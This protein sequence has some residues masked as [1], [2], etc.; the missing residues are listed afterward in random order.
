MPSAGRTVAA[1]VFYTINIAVEADYVAACSALEAA[2]PS[3]GLLPVAGAW[4]EAWVTYSA[5]AMVGDMANECWI[6]VTSSSAAA[7]T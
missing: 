1:Y 2:L 5:M 4:R 6:E 3:M 7:A